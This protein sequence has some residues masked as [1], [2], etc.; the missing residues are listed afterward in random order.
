MKASRIFAGV[1]GVALTA[2][3]AHFAIAAHADGPITA[4][5]WGEMVSFKPDTTLPAP[6]GTV[7]HKG[8]VDKIKGMIPPGL[9]KMVRKYELKMTLTDYAPIHPSLGYI[10]A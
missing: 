7:I 10:A 5:N 3:A 8:N 6:A 9:E 4:E 1:L 2:S